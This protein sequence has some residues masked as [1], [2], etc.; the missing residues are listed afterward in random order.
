M[1]WAFRWDV[2]PIPRDKDRATTMS[3]LGYGMVKGTKYPNQSWAFVR[4]LTRTLPT[5]GTGAAYVPALRSLA[6]SQEYA[7]L[8]PEG[9]T[10]GLRRQRAGRLHATC[11]TRFGARSPRATSC[12]SSLARNRPPMECRRVRQKL[13][14]PIRKWLESNPQ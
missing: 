5:S 11:A 8:Y 3:L 9:G 12:R 1:G 4:H 13:Q 14:P 10:T 7:A 2:A 6:L